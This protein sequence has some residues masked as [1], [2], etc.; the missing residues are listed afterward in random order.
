MHVI[1]RTSGKDQLEYTLRNEG[2]LIF[3]VKKQGVTMIKNHRKVVTRELIDS[4]VEAI[5]LYD[6]EL[7]HRSLM[8]DFVINEELNILDEI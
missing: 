7:M 4:V 3:A 5:T 1:A 6:N 8:S 2:E